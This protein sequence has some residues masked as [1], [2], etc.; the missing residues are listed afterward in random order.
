MSAR[1][2]FLVLKQP[3][4]Y[5]N[6]IE[7][8][9]I[10]KIPPINASSF[11]TAGAYE[12]KR[13]RSSEGIRLSDSYIEISFR[14]NTQA[15]AG[16]NSDIANITFENDVVS[17]LFDRVEL[18]I[19]NYPIE[20]VEHSHVA[21][22]MVGNVLYSTDEDRGSGA[23]MGWI[24]DYGAGSPELGLSGIIK[25]LNKAIPGMA[26]AGNAVTSTTAAITHANIGLAINNTNLS[27]VNQI[28][29]EKRKIFYNKS[30][31]KLSGAVAETARSCT[32][33]IPL[34][35]FFQSV[36][37]YDKLLSNLEFNILLTR[38]GVGIGRYVYSPVANTSMT[39][40]TSS[41]HWVVPYYRLTVDGQTFMT[42]QINSKE[43]QEMI[44]LVRHCSKIPASSTADTLSYDLGTKAN[45]PRYVL[46]AAKI[47]AL[48][49]AL[50]TNLTDTIGN[51][52]S[53]FTHANVTD[54]RISLGSETYPYL[55]LDSD[56]P[57]NK[58]SRVYMMFREFCKAMDV[59]PSIDYIDF[60]DRFTIFCFDLSARKSFLDEN[61]TTESMNLTITRSGNNLN[62]V[63][64]YVLQFLERHFNINFASGIVS[65]QDRT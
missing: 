12:F 4:I 20:V 46:V 29:Y 1:E 48:H 45:I 22:E 38:T 41:I 8:V 13:G 25:V 55:T 15:P 61:S 39:F 28:G 35:H 49:G 7:K 43:D 14:Y 63:E 36:T 30:Q 24:P 19:G 18:R 64:F 40:T 50:G 5:L 17:K 54:I 58:Y 44:C 11:D 56:F 51:N 34:Y 59:S 60:R 23:S 47:K 10:Q 21:T 52:N 62:S 6:N 9:N 33:C 31:E 26:V 27:D 16:T 2:K 57:N 3:K 65:S 53:L 37:S 42:K 32:L